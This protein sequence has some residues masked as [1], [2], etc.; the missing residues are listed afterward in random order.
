MQ[1]VNIMP[2]LVILSS[3]QQKLS[4]NPKVQKDQCFSVQNNILYEHCHKISTH[5]SFSKLY[6]FFVL[7]SKKEIL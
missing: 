5:S 1:T 4:E 2:L 7:I 3:R 6:I